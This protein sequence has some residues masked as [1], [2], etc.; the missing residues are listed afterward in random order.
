MY[1]NQNPNGG[2]FISKWK[3]SFPETFAQIS[4]CLGILIIIINNS[5]SPT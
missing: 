5:Q 1:M 2:L 3:H 4:P